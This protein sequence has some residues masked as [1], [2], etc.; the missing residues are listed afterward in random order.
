MTKLYFNKN[1][2]LLKH[3]APSDMNLYYSFLKL[4]LKSSLIKDLVVSNYGRKYEGPARRKSL[5]CHWAINDQWAG[6]VWTMTLWNDPF[7]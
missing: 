6:C 4:K 2:K 1:G 5:M 3:H 7:C